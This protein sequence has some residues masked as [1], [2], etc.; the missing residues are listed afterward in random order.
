MSEQK[1]MSRTERAALAEIAAWQAG[2]LSA[3]MNA[4]WWKQASMKKLAARGFVE[5]IPGLG[6]PAGVA[7]RVTDAGRLAAKD[8]A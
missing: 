1:P 6:S 7:W 4:Y 5:P 3:R 2:G 8:L